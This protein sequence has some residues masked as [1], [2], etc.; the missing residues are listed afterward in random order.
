MTWHRC[1]PPPRRRSGRPEFRGLLHRLTEALGLIVGDEGD[2]LAAASARRAEGHRRQGR[3]LRAVPAGAAEAACRPPCAPACGACS[4]AWPSPDCRRPTWSRCRAQPDWPAGFAEAM[5]WLEA[6]PVLLR[7]DIAETGRRRAGLGDAAWLR[8]PCRRALAS[9][10]SLK[11]E[12]LPVVLR[13]LGFRIVPAGVPGGGRIR[14]AGAG[15]AP[16][17]AAPAAP[18]VAEPPPA[19]TARS[20]RRSGGAE[21]LGGGIPDQEDRDWQRL[22]KW[23][24]CARFMR[25]RSD[26]AALVAQGRSASTASRP[27]RPMPGCASATC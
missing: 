5:G 23:L 15:D 6:G 20:V 24:W 25:Q 21:A 9:R 27:T 26:C 22:D 12:L 19:R 18:L 13:R 11:A 10:F 2:I 16:A 3:P 8:P 17:A 14:P 1:W 4:T 7:L